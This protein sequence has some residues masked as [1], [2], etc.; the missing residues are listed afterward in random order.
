MVAVVQT[1][2]ERVFHYVREW[3]NT[4]HAS[5]MNTFW[6]STKNVLKITLFDYM[7]LMSSLKMLLNQHR[8]PHHD[9][10]NVSLIFNIVRSRLSFHLKSLCVWVSFFCN[11]TFLFYDFDSVN[12]FYYGFFLSSYFSISFAVVLFCFGY[13]FGCNFVNKFI[14]VV[15]DFVINFSV[16][17]LWV[18]S[19]MYREKTRFMR[20][21]M[22]SVALLC[23]PRHMLLPNWLLVELWGYLLTEW[24]PEGALTSSS[25]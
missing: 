10:N 6:G 17:P 22:I 11:V 13:E 21:K 14:R 5:L 1:Q 2:S 16:F 8:T 19:C 20:T 3:N 7:M 24:P 23:V 9:Y 4:K 18:M 15:V 12:Y 25:P